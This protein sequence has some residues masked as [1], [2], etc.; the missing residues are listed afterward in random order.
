MKGL[1][2]APSLAVEQEAVLHHR[3]RWLAAPLSPYS[4]PLRYLPCLVLCAGIMHGL[5]CWFDIEFRG[6][7]SV[8]VLS[9]GPDSPG[10]HW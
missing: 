9:T 5:G 10:T 4:Y 1:A 3:M 2:A 8:V 7:G 6:T